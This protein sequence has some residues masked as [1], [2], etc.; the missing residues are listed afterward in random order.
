MTNSMQE[1]INITTSRRKKQ[2]EYN[3]IHN[4][5]PKSVSRKVEKSLKSEDYG[6]LLRQESKKIQKIPP[7]QKQK[8]IKELTKKMHEAA[9]KLEFEEAARI[10][11]EIAK[12]RKL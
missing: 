7:S 10:R 3:K 9:K 1:A 4:I 2:Q 12:I 6:E 11:D 5:T 8:I